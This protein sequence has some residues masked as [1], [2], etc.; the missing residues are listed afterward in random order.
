MPLH[1]FGFGDNDGVLVNVSH[2]ILQVHVQHKVAS[3]ANPQQRSRLREWKRIELCQNSQN[4]RS[5][6]DEHL[7]IFP[8]EILL[9]WRLRESLRRGIVQYLLHL[10]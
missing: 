6:H 4:A 7:N 8:G 1:L 10:Y 9:V 5:K 3:A 2:D